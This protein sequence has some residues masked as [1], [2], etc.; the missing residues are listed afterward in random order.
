MNIQCPNCLFSDDI[1]ERKIP[2]KG[3][4]AKCPKCSHRFPVKRLQNPHPPPDRFSAQTVAFKV[5][6]KQKSASANQTAGASPTVQTKPPL[7]L[8]HKLSF[9]GN[10]SALFGIQIVNIL[11]TIITLGIYRFW[12][13]VKVRKYLYSQ[14]ELLGDRFV[15]HGTGKEL[16]IGWLKAVGVLIIVY[17]LIIGLSRFIHPLLFLLIYPT[18]IVIIPFALVGARR[19]RLSRTSWHGIRFSF[20]GSF[21]EALGLYAGGLL[22]TIITLGIYYPIFH[23]KMRSFWANNSY[24]GNTPFK[25]NGN[26]KDLLGS[27]ILAVFL[28]I[29]TLGIYWFWYMAKVQQYD[30]EHTSFPGMSFR[31]TVTGGSLFVLTLTN[32]LLIIFTLGLAFSWVIVRTMRFWFAN[33][34]L[35]GNIELD[36]IKQD[37]QNARATADSMAD[38]M[39]I[40]SGLV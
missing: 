22:L 37:A 14:T 23:A 16:F 35:E 26:G 13:K 5:P 31:S 27:F 6:E 1:D 40:D 2:E 10:G 19:Y 25:Y 32:F 21:K 24:F 8:V 7:S 33:I 34:S 38:F 11:L 3:G 30:W 17:A 18:F 15:Y 28:S 36:K 39:N 9:H 20:R 12:G 29:V 4:N